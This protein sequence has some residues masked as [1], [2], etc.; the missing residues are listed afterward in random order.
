M[1]LYWIDVT[2]SWIRILSH[3]NNLAKY[4]EY[5]DPILK[6]APLNFIC[7]LSLIFIAAL[8]VLLYCSDIG[9]R[10]PVSRSGRTWIPLRN[11]KLTDRFPICLLTLKCVQPL[12]ISIHL[13]LAKS[14]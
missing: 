12:N 14:D 11:L 5:V 13:V 2:G 10:L 6:C 4:P 8:G 3:G 1:L 7:I 9:S